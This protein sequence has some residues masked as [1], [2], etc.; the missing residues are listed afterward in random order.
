MKYL[1]NDIYS[2]VELLSLEKGMHVGKKQC[3]VFFPIPVR[4]DQSRVMP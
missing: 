3:Q 2:I 1:F 4:Y